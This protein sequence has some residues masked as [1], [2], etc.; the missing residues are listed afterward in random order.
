MNSIEWFFEKAKK[1]IKLDS[2]DLEDLF[3]YYYQSRVMQ[4]REIINAHLDGQSLVSCKDEYAEQYYQ[5][6]FGSK[7][8]EHTEQHLEEIISKAHTKIIRTK[9]KE[10]A[11]TANEIQDAIS[12]EEI[13]KKAKEFFPMNDSDVEM[14]KKSMWKLGAKWYREQLKTK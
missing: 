14:T 4:R 1:F 3:V 9:G 10:Y 2:D 13:D 6:T 11:P 7:G 12:D 8:S 5:E